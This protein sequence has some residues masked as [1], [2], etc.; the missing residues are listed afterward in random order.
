MSNT[1]YEELEKFK[2]SKFLNGPTLE[3]HLKA[4][5]AKLCLEN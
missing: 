1:L 4:I 2:C 3:A 5:F